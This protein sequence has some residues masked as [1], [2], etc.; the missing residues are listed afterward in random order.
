LNTRNRDKRESTN[1]RCFILLADPAMSLLSPNYRVVTTEING[2]PATSFSDTLKALELVTISGEIRNENDESVLSSF[3]GELFP[4]FYDKPSKYRTLGQDD[5]SYPIDFEEQN[6]II[7]KGNVS[8]QNGK[9]SFKFVVPK[10]IAY[11][12]DN[13]KLS[14]YAK[15][16]GLNHAGGVELSYK[17]GGTADSII[18]DDKF[19]ELKLYLDDEDWVFG[20]IT[21]PT[22]NL[23]ATLS[24]SNGINT[25]G[26]GIGREMEAILD[27]GTDAE[28]SIVLNDF[29]RPDLNSYQSG[30]IEYP[31]EPLSAGR[32]TLSLKV[33]DVYNNSAEAYTE[34][35]VSESEDI[36]IA[37]VLNYPNPFNK[38]T[39]FH[40][41]HNKAGQE[42]TVNVIISSVAGNVVKSI[43]QTFANA[44]SHS[45]DITWDGRDDYGDNLAK[46]VYIYTLTVAAEDGS[47][48]SKTEKLYIIN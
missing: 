13:G 16:A 45:S 43:T 29:Y 1:A 2:Q 27:K 15:D 41:D 44:S 18:N 32:H 7:Y 38:N 17:I 40:F 12:V 31:F 25:I 28:K 20:G 10:D 14:Y 9:F 30:K 6:R 11:N 21:S 19:D 23:F 46:G 8:V 36:T 37:N 3:N 22:P 47:K 42:I 35:V 33:W 26:S 39:V 24:D 34:F 48:Q 5:E 4:T